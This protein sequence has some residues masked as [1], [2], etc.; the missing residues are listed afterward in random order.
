MPGFEEIQKSRIDHLLVETIKQVGVS[1]YSL[2]ARLTGLNPETVR[3]KVNRQLTRMGLGISVNVDFEGLGFKRGIFYVKASAI[4]GKSWLDHTNYLTFIGKVMGV[5]RYLCMYAVPYRLKKKYLDSLLYLQQSGV[6]EEVQPLDVSWVR[7]PSFRSEFY[8][9]DRGCWQ[10]DWT[11]VEM[12]LRETGVASTLINRDVKL[13]YF[14]L[15]ILR[16]MQEDPT[17]SIAKTAKEMNANPRTVRYHYAEHV[18]KSR[19]VLGHNVRWKRPA[20]DGKPVDLMHLVFSLSQLSNEEMGVARKIFNKIPFTWLEVGNEDN[21]YFA[22]LDTSLSNFHETVRFVERN[23]DPIRNR[24]EMLT[25]DPLKTRSINIPD[26][27]YDKERG[28]TLPIVR[29]VSETSK[30]GT[31]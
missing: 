4:S 12:T 19:F 25:L 20:T 26:E 30:D 27:M 31:A 21:R 15:K 29:T 11:R 28:W 22:F 8:D 2:I 23:T 10:V 18:L 24:L 6:V 17:S 9:F 3:Y 7:Y 13:D 1:N 5:D 16:Y 14:D